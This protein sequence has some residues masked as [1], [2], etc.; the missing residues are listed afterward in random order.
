MS[1]AVVLDELDPSV[2][3]RVRHPRRGDL[4]SALAALLLL[5]GLIATLYS[6]KQVGGG[7][8]AALGLLALP[9]CVLLI[10]GAQRA[11][12]DEEDAKRPAPVMDFE[13]S[14]R[15]AHIGT[16]LRR[17]RTDAPRV[18]R[19]VLAHAA[20][21]GGS[22]RTLEERRL[23]HPSGEAFDLLAE[24]RH[25][26]ERLLVRYALVPGPGETCMVLSLCAKPDA[27]SAHEPAFEDLVAS[28]RLLP[29]AEAL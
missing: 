7:R 26:E 4:R 12:R 11:E 16:V 13:S 3:R 18:L 2:W 9:L 14:R 15:D 22:A 6:A 5:A 1:V 10:R 21:V 25:G 27:W 29:R 24:L 19:D 17:L 28:V 8:G 20:P 23:P